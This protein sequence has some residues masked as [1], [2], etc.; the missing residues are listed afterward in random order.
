MSPA[1]ERLVGQLLIGAAIV[2][3]IVTLIVLLLMPRTLTATNDGI[4][5]TLATLDGTLTT[6]DQALQLVGQSVADIDSTMQTA[7]SAT[8]EVS[9]ALSDTVPLISTMAEITGEELPDSVIAAQEA[10]AAAEDSATS[11]EGVLTGLNDSLVIFGG[12]PLYDPDQSFATTLADLSGSLDPLVE[13]MQLVRASLLVTN[14][15]LTDMQAEVE[16]L[17][18]NFDQLGETV[19]SASEITGQ[20]EQVIAEQQALVEELQGNATSWMRWIS[21]FVL[22]VLV[23]LLVAQIGLLS[24]GLE[25]YHRGRRREAL[26]AESRSS[27]LQ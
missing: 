25:M 14:Q 13:S 1:M 22:L 9:T 3:L 7:Q 19:D 15:N 18:D 20:Y 17:S 6:T 8:L 21:L 11:I 5:E 10:L 24:Q 26:L 27:S 16:A 12:A 2:G 4:Q 23:L